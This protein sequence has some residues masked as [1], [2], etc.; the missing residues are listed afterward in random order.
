MKSKPRFKFPDEDSQ[1]DVC[2][3]ADGE[4]QISGE[5]LDALK[6]QAKEARMPLKKFFNQ[7]MRESLHKIERVLV[8][9]PGCTNDEIKAILINESI[10]GQE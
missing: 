9:N 2:I 3:K 10:W 4:I 8:E 5:A 7:Q 6:R 1:P